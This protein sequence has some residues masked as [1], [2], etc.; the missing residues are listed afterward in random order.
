[1]VQKQQKSLEGKQVHKSIVPIIPRSGLSHGKPAHPI[2][3]PFLLDWR[4]KQLYRQ[5]VPMQ[6][7]HHHPAV[8]ITTQ[9]KSYLEVICSRRQE[10][11]T[12]VE[13]FATFDTS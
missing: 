7:Q 2:A 3:A 5:V 12:Y 13:G 4:S 10:L 9:T 1:M 11:I 6:D 8:L